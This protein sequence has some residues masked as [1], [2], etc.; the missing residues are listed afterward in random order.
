MS[1]VIS[2]SKSVAKQGLLEQQSLTPAFNLIANEILKPL[3]IAET[4]SRASP[5]ALRMN[6]DVIDEKKILNKLAKISEEFGMVF[7]VASEKSR[8]QY[9][10]DGTT[11]VLSPSEVEWYFRTKKMP[12]DI[13]GVLGNREDIHI[14]FDFKIY[15]D[16]GEFLGFIGVGKRLQGFITA[17]ED[18]KNEFGYEFV[19]VDQN[20]DVV[21]SSDT[22]IVADGNRIVSLDELPWYKALTP[23]QHS[24]SGYENSLVNVDGEDFLI[25]KAE[26]KALNWKLFLINSLEVRQNRN[27]KHFVVQTLYIIGLVLVALLFAWMFIRYTWAEFILKFQKDVVTQLP[28]RAYI[29][30]R[31]EKISNDKRA[32]SV[33]ISDIDFF[34]T[35]NDTHGHA[36][37]DKVLNEI[38]GIFKSLI[39]EQDVAARWG[40]DEF[41]IVLPLASLSVAEEI[42]QRAQI[43]I[44]KH[45]FMFDGQQLH[46]TASFG[47]TFSQDNR[48]LEEIVADADKALYEAKKSGRNSVHTTKM[49]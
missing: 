45:E 39:R 25:A 34:K 49:S 3:F 1:A 16:T 32:L 26:L 6:E 44:S 33:I 27:T 48:K 23:E 19:F 21:L 30:A 38:A 12:Q 18:F 22:S 11:L 46:I 36:A 41:V 43:A 9:N 14:Y 42:A 7:F 40:G 10:S 15:N 17:F 5:L 47:V 13:I 31:F 24:E 28:N 8:I 2:L 29:S 35:I 37:G 4:I 20:N